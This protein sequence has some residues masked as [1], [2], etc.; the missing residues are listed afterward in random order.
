MGRFAQKLEQAPFRHKRRPLFPNFKSLLKSRGLLALL[1][2]HRSCFEWQ[3][4]MGG[5]SP[6]EAAEWLWLGLKKQD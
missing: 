4:N 3:N 2:G 1:K 5:S 6:S